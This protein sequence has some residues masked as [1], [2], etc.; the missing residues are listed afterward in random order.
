M[1]QVRGPVPRVCLSPVKGRGW[2]NRLR[3]ATQACSD[4]RSS[5]AVTS[6]NFRILR[7]NKLET[8]FQLLRRCVQEISN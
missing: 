8:S 4:Y 2:R 7:V 3:H 1:G 6:C 5:Q